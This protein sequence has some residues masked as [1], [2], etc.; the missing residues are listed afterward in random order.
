MRIHAL[1][2]LIVLLSGFF[3]LSAC[4]VKAQ[5]YGLKTGFVLSTLNGQGNNSIR[6]GFQFGAYKKFGATEKLFVQ[7]E[8]L[9]SQKGAWN[10]E[11]DNVNNINLYYFDFAI[12]F[13]ILLDEKFTLNLGIQPSVFLGGNY[14]YVV[15][16][17]EQIENLSG[18]VSLMDY[19][20]IFGLEYVLS[21]NFAIG[22]RFN[23]S[24]VPI[25]SYENDFSDNNELPFSM[26]FQL[27]GK[28]KMEKIKAWLKK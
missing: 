18:R 20:T 14:K 25:Q 19:A 12:M 26:L 16:D 28:V 23:Y 21:E 10:W 5:D 17:E 9:L 6:P 3:I 15:D 24:F 4:R 22:S 2:G 11:E 13:G 8:A 7:M 27:Y 1:S